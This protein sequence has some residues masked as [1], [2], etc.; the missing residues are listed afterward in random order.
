MKN[1]SVALCVLVVLASASC[2]RRSAPV[3]VPPAADAPGQF[4]VD[5]WSLGPAVEKGFSA[6][7][8]T[9]VTVDRGD[10]PV[11]ISDTSTMT[12]LPGGDFS[13]RRTRVHK[14]AA[15]GQSEES[16][17]AVRL[18]SDYYT[19]GSSGLWVR[20]DDAIGQPAG[21]V[22]GFI[23]N[24]DSLAGIVRQCG[25]LGPAD[26]VGRSPVTM[27]S[28]GCRFATQRGSRPTKPWSG[29]VTALDGF[30]VLDG[31]VP[32][33]TSVKLRFDTVVDGVPAEVGLAWALK[34]TFGAGLPEVKAPAE[35]SDSRRPRP[36]RMVES[37]LGDMVDEWGPGAPENLGKPAAK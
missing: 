24:E 16:T 9:V 2:E 13:F 8:T 15:D 33:E 23:E 14:G 28:S 27:S 7:S 36:V 22:A 19:A 25:R 12:I 21:Q 4:P 20:W 29:N 10:S 1:V 35:F 18:G 6:V 34:V 37:V 31:K 17:S 3:A 30:V 11:E 32:V 26:E 5:G